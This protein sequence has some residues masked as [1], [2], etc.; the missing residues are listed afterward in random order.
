MAQQP[1]TVTVAAVTHHGRVRHSNEDC[2]L[3][4]GWASVGDSNLTQQFTLAKAH[5]LLVAVL[6]GMGGHDGGDVAS[7][8]AAAVLAATPAVTGTEE[9]RERVLAAD[10]AL[11]RAASPLQLA[12]MGT[13][14]VGFLLGTDDYTV[15]NVGD[16]S[17]FRLLHGRLGHLSVTDGRPD[18]RQPGATVLT[19]V[20][21]GTVTE[22]EVHQETYPVGAP[23][24]LLL[25]SDGFTDVVQPEQTRELLGAVN[26]EQAA[27]ALLEA[28]LEGGG[29][30]NISVVVVDL[31]PQPVEFSR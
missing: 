30:D 8:V 7:R 22:L 9:L 4:G 1:T 27:A 12:G 29:P 31:D 19:Q 6:D 5:P 25:C 21:G 26:A 18:P 28:A 11:L 16:S 23:V 20:L 3:V 13:T 14:V 15:F 17:A 10:R 2:V 24:R